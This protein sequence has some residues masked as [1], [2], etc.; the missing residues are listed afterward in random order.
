MHVNPPTSPPQVEQGDNY[1][2]N[3]L[4]ILGLFLA[5]TPLVSLYDPCSR[6]TSY[7]CSVSHRSEAKTDP[8]AIEEA[9]GGGAYG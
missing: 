7:M 9:I 4:P 3:F 2:D 5:Q 1:E 6:E 8:A